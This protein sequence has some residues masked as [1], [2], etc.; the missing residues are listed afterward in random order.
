MTDPGYPADAVQAARSVLIE[1]AHLL[2]QYREETVLI[3][4]WVPEL[5]MPGQGHVGSMDV[6]LL[7]DHRA[8]AEPRYDTLHDLLAGHGYAEASQPF[9]FQRLVR[10]AG[11]DVIVEVDLLADQYGGTGRQH[12]TQPALGIRAHKIRGGSLA[13]AAADEVLVAGTLPDGSQ[14]AVRVRVASIAPFL[15]LKALAMRERLKPK[16]AYDVYFCLRH[17]PGGIRAVADRLIALGRI[18][19]TIEA[20]QSLRESFASTDHVGPRHAASFLAADDPELAEYVRRDAFELVRELLG[21]VTF[22]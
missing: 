14:D 22:R 18:R 4:G 12:R 16:D 2:G 6:D 20:L 17:Y 11:R 1:L 21:A 3:G 7:L 19:L 13:L 15:V 5:L 9:I 10:H 8:L